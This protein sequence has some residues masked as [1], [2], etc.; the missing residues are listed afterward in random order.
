MSAAG[1]AK[2]RRVRRRAI[3]HAADKIMPDD[4][5]LAAEAAT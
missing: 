1:E 4:S 3:A 5:M 2:A